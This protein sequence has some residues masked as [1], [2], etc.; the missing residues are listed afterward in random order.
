MC[1]VSRKIHPTCGHQVPGT[2]A[3][4]Y[5]CRDAGPNFQR[6]LPGAGLEQHNEYADQGYCDACIMTSVEVAKAKGMDIDVVARSL[7]VSLNDLL[8]EHP[9]WR[10]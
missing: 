5:Y 10:P 2:V 8:R 1:I 3:Q 4:T 9:S 6:C 7:G